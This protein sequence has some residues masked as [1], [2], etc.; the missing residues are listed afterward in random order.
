MS[1]ASIRQ[2]AIATHDDDEHQS[3]VQIWTAGNESHSQPPATIP[4]ILSWRPLTLNAQQCRRQKD[5]YG[6]KGLQHLNEGDG[7]SE[8]VLAMSD[9][10]RACQGGDSRK[11]AVYGVRRNSASKRR[12]KNS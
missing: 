2:T 7:Q 6:R 1:S 9:R 11:V 5:R 10:E 3:R 8:V 12:I 4:S